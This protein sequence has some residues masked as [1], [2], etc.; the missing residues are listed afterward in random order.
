MSATGRYFVRMDE[1]IS[2]GVMRGTLSCRGDSE[3][4]CPALPAPCDA[5]AGSRPAAPHREPPRALLRPGLRRRRE[6]RL[7]A[8]AP[9]PQRG[10]FPARHHLL[11]DG[12]LRDLV[13]L[14]ELHLVRDLLR[15][16]RL[17][18]PRHD[19]RPDGRRPRLRRGHPPGVHRG[20]LH[21]PGPR[22]RRDARRDGRAVAAGIPISG[23]AALGH[24][25]VRLRDRGGAGAV[26]PLPPD[27]HRAVA[28]S[29]RSWCSR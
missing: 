24:T 12:V 11:C 3:H 20:G 5:P 1:S 16:R 4:R 8:A 7:R 28:V 26:D 29:R 25:P 27:P 17:A 2:Q 10:R 19:V 21:R 6:H 23:S 22:L 13:G 14:D 18:V 15:H 9:R